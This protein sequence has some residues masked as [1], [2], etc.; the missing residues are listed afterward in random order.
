MGSD[1]RGPADA[2]RHTATVQM[3]ASVSDDMDSRKDG[4]AMGGV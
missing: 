1:G 3:D 2:E 4:G